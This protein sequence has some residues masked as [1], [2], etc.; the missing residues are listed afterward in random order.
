MLLRDSF[1]VHLVTAV[2]LLICLVPYSLTFLFGELLLL[3]NVLSSYLL[4]SLP[5]RFIVDASLLGGLQAKLNLLLLVNDGLLLILFDEEEP[6]N[7]VL[8][9]LNL[10]GQLFIRV[11]NRSE[12]VVTCIRHVQGLIWPMKHCTSS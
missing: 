9:L 4:I 12:R 1:F 10:I 7:L 2:V 5:P 6:G 8:L 11:M 3:T